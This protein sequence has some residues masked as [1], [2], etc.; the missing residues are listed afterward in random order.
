MKRFKKIILSVM[1]FAMLLSVVNLKEVNAAGN[2]FGNAKSINVNST[3]YDYLS[4]YNEKDYYKFTMANNGNISLS[5][6]KG[7]DNVDHHKWI[8]RLYNSSQNEIMTR[9]FYAGNTNTET[10]CKV[11][12][13]K[14][15]YYI[16]IAVDNSSYCWSDVTYNIKV[17]YSS[18]NIWEKEF[19]E[20]PQTAN[21]ISTGKTYYGSLREYNDKDY[22][23]FTMANNGNISLSFGKGYD[24]E[25]YHKWIVRLYNSS[26]SE[27]MT[28]EFYAGD[29]NTETTCKVGL[30][31]GTYYIKI[32]A[33]NSSYRWSDVTYNI[34]VNY[35]V[36][37]IWEKEF[38]E[39]PQTVNTISTGKTYYGSLREYNDKDYYKFT[40][41]DNSYV[42][43]YFYGNDSINYHRWIAT[44]YNGSLNSNQTYE[45][46]SGNSATQRTTKMYLPKGT[47][48]IKID[49]DNDSYYWSD[50]TYNF[51]LTTSFTNISLNLKANN[52]NYNKVKLSWNKDGHASGYEIYRSTS[53]GGKYTKFKTITN[54]NITSYI[55]TNLTTNKTYYYK[56]RAY[57]KTSGLTRYGAYSTI[58]S[59]KPTLKKVTMKS[60]KPNK[61]AV[62]IKFKK[63]AGATG[64]QIAY[65]KKG[66]SKWVKI[67]VSH[68]VLSKKITKLTSK[69]TYYFKVRAYR[70]VNRKK[71]Y[72]AYSNIKNCKVK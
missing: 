63:V 37:S 17:N 43:L 66:S 69:K 21:A 22:Y 34:K 56:I 27:I 20:T 57:K 4:D 18:S 24:N 32:D 71:V 11:G 33:D 61:K 44:V 6:G 59:A 14:G 48:Y 16:K 36:S 47:Y 55:D 5:F 46:Q 52:S 39:T 40:L 53:K 15:T 54:K 64:Y 62:T 19:N 35:S 72:G 38:N 58:K 29:S 67:N 2:T 8:V 70:T 50:Y 25:G 10:T 26:Q 12:L 28:R 31:K 3:Y 30:P 49:A 13:P 41:I 68:K 65:R 60:T 45:F 23:K 9:E 42:Q 1:L 7:Y 51:R